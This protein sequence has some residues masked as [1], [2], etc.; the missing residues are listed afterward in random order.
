MGGKRVN[1]FKKEEG[2]TE[3]NC[4]QMPTVD[5]RPFLLCFG[6]EEL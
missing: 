2:T 1:T 4:S 5:I 3:R 6:T